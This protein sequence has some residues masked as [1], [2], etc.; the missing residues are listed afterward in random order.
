MADRRQSEFIFCDPSPAEI[1]QIEIDAEL[2]RLDYLASILADS[3]DEDEKLL[4]EAELYQSMNG[5][6]KQ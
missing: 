4:A 6:W 5:S 2:A 1:K 3:D